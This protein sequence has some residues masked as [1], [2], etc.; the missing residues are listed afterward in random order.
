MKVNYADAKSYDTNGNGIQKSDFVKYATK[1][2]GV[3][4][5]EAK[6]LFN[7]IDAND[8]GGLRKAEFDK[9]DR[10]DSNN[11]DHA[12][13]GGDND[14]P[15]EGGN[16]KG[17]SSLNNIPGVKFGDTQRLHR[18]GKKEG[19]KDDKINTNGADYLLLSESHGTNHKQMDINDAPVIVGFKCVGGG[20]SGDKSAYLYKRTSDKNE[21]IIK[22]NIGAGFVTKIYSKSDLDFN[23]YTTDPN[24]KDT[25]RLDRPNPNEIGLYFEDEGNK[26]DRDEQFEA[27]GFKTIHGAGRDDQIKIMPNS[28]NEK[29]VPN[30]NGAQGFISV[31]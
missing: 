19:F 30:G 6:S 18:D 11:T 10:G 15:T 24:Y 17:G 14:Q 4:E 13:G 21:V 29:D 31:N 28:W 12:I 3:S 5:G 23:A 9:S 20:G 26:R 2:L 1:E 16:N 7:K 22:G 25:K 27:A 8:S